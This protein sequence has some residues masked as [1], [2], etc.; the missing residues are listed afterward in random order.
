MEDFQRKVIWKLNFEAGER[1]KDKF[2]GRKAQ[3]GKK[4]QKVPMVYVGN[5]SRGRQKG[6]RTGSVN[7]FEI[8]SKNKNLS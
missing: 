1:R 7:A 2:S 4:Q 8:Y 3:R 5:G 6:P